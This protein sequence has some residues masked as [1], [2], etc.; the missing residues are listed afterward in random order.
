MRV[1]ILSS[2]LLLSLFA[3]QPERQ[4]DTKVLQANLLSSVDFVQGS[5]ENPA[6]E[7]LVGVYFMPSWN[8]STDPA[9]DRDS[10]WSCLQDPKN[11]SSLQNPGIW[12]PKGRVYNQRFP[13][14]RSI[15]RQ[16]TG[17]RIRRLLQ[18]RRSENNQKA[19]SNDEKLWD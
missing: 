12:G 6:D 19:A 11:C 3:C 4:S 15:S 2:I 14:R 8:T 17:R 13:V 5:D 7:E 1:S 9:V 16:K 18:A 10:F